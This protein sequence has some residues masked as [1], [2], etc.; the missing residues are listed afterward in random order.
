MR[1]FGVPPWNSAG[2]VAFGLDAS[3]LPLRVLNSA[4]LRSL[5]QQSAAAAFV[6]LPLLSKTAGEN[7]WEHAA[8]RGVTRILVVVCRSH[9][10]WRHTS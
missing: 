6:R 3:I 5:V 7:G 8:A 10:S 9:W 2:V 4:R 1:Q